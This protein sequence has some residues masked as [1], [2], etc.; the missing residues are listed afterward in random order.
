MAQA[1]RLCAALI[2]AWL[3][4]VCTALPL[5]ASADNTTTVST[6]STVEISST[7]TTSTTT[8]HGE[9]IHYFVGLTGGGR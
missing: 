4:L 5:E 3:V 7:S 2:A 9:G 6:V 1:A 8:A